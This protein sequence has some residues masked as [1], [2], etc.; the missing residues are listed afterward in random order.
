MHDNHHDIEVVKSREG[1]R[2]GEE[3]KEG[4]EEGKE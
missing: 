3:I 4:R 1:G 2:E